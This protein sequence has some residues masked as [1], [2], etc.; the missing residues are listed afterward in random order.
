MPHSRYTPALSLLCLGIAS[1]ALAAPPLPAVHERALVVLREGLNSGQF[2]PSMHAAEALSRASHGAEVRAALESRLPQEPD[3]QRRCGLAR[4][5]YRAGDRSAAATLFEVLGS[6]NPH[7]H[8]H[9]AES[10]Y[11]L[12]LVG[13]GRALQAAF[14]EQSPPQL[15]IMAAG[16]LAAHGDATAMQ[17]VRSSLTSRDRET[18][19]TAVWLLGSIGQP[20][21]LVALRVALAREADASMRMS[22]ALAMA[23]LGDPAG[24]RLL[25]QGLRAPEASIRAQSAASAAEVAADPELISLLTGLLGDPDLDVRIRAAQALLTPLAVRLIPRPEE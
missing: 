4:E 2:W 21:D 25:K 19:R 16:A 6:A 11:K 10:L 24:L 3:D 17:F 14:T 15:R 23:T 1:T 7:A 5:L 20:R 13:D 12:R 9:A 22:I 18:A 8:V